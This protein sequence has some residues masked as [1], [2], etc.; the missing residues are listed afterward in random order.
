[1]TIGLGIAT[2]A[3]AFIFPFVL[4]LSWGPMVKEWGS[5]GGWMAAAFIVGTIWTLNHGISTPLIHQTGV[6]VD[7]GLAVGIGVWVSSTIVGGK[8]SQSVKNIISAV[9]GGV[10]AGALLSLVLS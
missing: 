3:G 6:W 4:R 5:L 2:V 10:L 9:V 1:M 7:Q 8:A